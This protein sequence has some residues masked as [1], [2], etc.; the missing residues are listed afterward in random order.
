MIDKNFQSILW[1]YDLNKLNY[2]D[3]IVFVRTLIF[4]NKK[5]VDILK[6]KLW[7][8]KF[9]EK[10]LENL[11]HFDKKT[12]NYWSIILDVKIDLKNKQTIYEQL[13]KPIFTRNFG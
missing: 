3:D 4:W 10:F 7:K 2:N 5:Q 1:E 11:T 9:K 13:N 6:N 8:E 12:L